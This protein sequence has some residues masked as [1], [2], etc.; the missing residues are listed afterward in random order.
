MLFE[1]DSEKAASNFSKHGVSFEESVQVWLGR[2]VEFDSNVE[3]EPRCVV[4]GQV[5][6]EVLAVVYTQRGETKRII[7]ARFAS[8]QERK[9]YEEG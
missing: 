6:G 7:S 8:R 4:L 3:S 5:D 1:W 9:R 2:I